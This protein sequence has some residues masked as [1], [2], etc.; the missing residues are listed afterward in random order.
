MVAQKGTGQ[1]SMNSGEFAPDLAGRV[2]IKQ[3]Y[4]AGLRFLNIEPVAQSGFRNLPGTSRISLAT[5]SAPPRFW[6]LKRSRTESFFVVLLPGR[7]DIFKGLV[8]V[9]QVPISEITVDIQREAQLYLEADTIGIF[10]RDLQSRRVVRVNDGTWAVDLWP[11]EK[12]PDVDYGGDYVKTADVW[13]VFFRWADG[14]QLIAANFIVNGEETGSISYANESGS[15]TGPAFANQVAAAISAL[16]SLGPGVT[17]VWS[18][19]PGSNSNMVTVTFGGALTGEEYELSAQVLNTSDASS[20]AAHKDVGETAG[21]PAIS[22]SQGWPGVP[23]IVQ[24]RLVYAALRAKPS[25]LLLSRTAEYFNVNIESIRDD[26][27]K[28]E[29]LRTNA[30]EEILHVKDSKYLLVFTDEAEYFASNREIKREEP[31]NFVET[32]R[33]GLSRGTWPVEIENRIYYVAQRGAVLFSTAYDDVGQAFEARM[34]SLLAPHLIDTI[35]MTDL[36]RGTDDSD[37]PRLW[38]LRSDG[39]LV[40][41]SVI[42]D[43][44]ITAFFEY[45]VGGPVRSIGVDPSNRLWLCVE[46]SGGYAYEV[47]NSGSYLVSSVALTADGNGRVTGLHHAEGATVYAETG[48][49]TIGPFTVSGGAIDTGWPSAAMV[50]GE[51]VAPRWESMPRVLVTGDDKI[52]R[53]PGR[54]HTLKVNV[55]NT[56]SIAIGANGTP[57][58]D[59]V[60]LRTSDPVDQPMP[61]KTQLVTAAGIPG[62]KL[63]TTAVI[64]QIRPGPLRVRDVTFEERL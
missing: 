48:G 52:V 56:T 51:W 47:M 35:V 9:A 39:R 3:Y 37:A 15:T 5:A 28:L 38:L 6:R 49:Y 4:S 62:V 16:P 12:I 59:Q 33:N 44:D 64:S 34:E 25:G 2:D 55:M 23:A 8:L 29:A 7:L 18:D 42:R 60:L 24:D 27:A 63:D 43:Q 13:E 22:V 17:A 32:S 57:P 26:A 53:R 30:K 50:V 14:V 10:H 40:G 20:L 61:A 58:R 41:A 36:Q 31:L 45:D 19:T 46:R 54:I 21:E 11:Y 1:Q